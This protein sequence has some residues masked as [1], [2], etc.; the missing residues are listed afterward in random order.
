M[1]RRYVEKVLAMALAITVATTPVSGI[2]FAA[3]ED[4]STSE[5]KVEEPA[6]SPPQKQETPV[7]QT[8]EPQQEAPAS[9][10]QNAENTS[11]Q[12]EETAPAQTAGTSP[13]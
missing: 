9:E 3:E 7:E 12:T 10:Q 4:A 1:K 8:S 2:A 11:A 13:C 6:A 5:V